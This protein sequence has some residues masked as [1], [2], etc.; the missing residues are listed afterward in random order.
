MTTQG[1]H[2]GKVQPVHLFRPPH[3][4]AGVRPDH[5]AGR[6][7]VLEERSDGFRVQAG[8]VIAFQERIHDELP[9]RLHRMGLAPEERVTGQAECVHVGADSARVDEIG[10]RVAMREPDQPPAFLARQFDQIV[11][12]L[13]EAGEAVRPGQGEQSSVHRIGPGVVR[14]DQPFRAHRFLPLDQPRAAVAAGI[15]EDMRFSL[16]ISRHEQRDSGRVVRHGHA[17][18]G[19][20]GG[21]AKDLRQFRVDRCLLALEML[22]IGI[23]R[24]GDGFDGG[25]PFLAA[26]CDH[27]RQFELAFSRRVCG[28]R[29]SRCRFV[30]HA[31]SV[32]LSGSSEKGPGSV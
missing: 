27:P 5:V 14:A 3:G 4:G 26:L 11:V 16:R 19:Q 30:H 1:R 28:T 15:E 24:G 20:K 31:A 13:V 2:V 29:G 10:L 21:G 22:R 32:A 9:V 17:R 7:S 18:L 25:G 6:H 23:Q 12:G 8:D